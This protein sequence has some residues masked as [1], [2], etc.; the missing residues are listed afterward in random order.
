MK[1]LAAAVCTLVFATGCSHATPEPVPAR[2]VLLTAADSAANARVHA[3]HGLQRMT[4]EEEKYARPPEFFPYMLVRV[5]VNKKIVG[6]PGM[7]DYASSVVWVW[8]EKD[9]GTKPEAELVAAAG[10]KT[11]DTWALAYSGIVVPNN[12]GSRYNLIK[13]VYKEVL[14]RETV[15]NEIPCAWNIFRE[16]F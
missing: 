4:R 8:A 16:T 12:A 14:H 10:C 1:K 7:Y 3:G 15:G 11:P 13:E 2:A 6:A 9:H 5:F